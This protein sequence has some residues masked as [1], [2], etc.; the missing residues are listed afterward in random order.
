V[1][2]ACAENLVELSK[3][4]SRETFVKV[5][6]DLFEPLANDVSFQVRTAALEKL[7]PLVA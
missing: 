6:H 3:C 5:A 7:G 4:F 2:R 1:R